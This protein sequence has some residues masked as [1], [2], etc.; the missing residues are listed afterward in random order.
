MDLPEVQQCRPLSQDPCEDL[1]PLAGPASPR[2]WDWAN[3]DEC[4]NLQVCAF[5]LVPEDSEPHE[6]LGVYRYR[7]SR[8][9][10]ELA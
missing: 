7:E 3:K 2:R 10:P 6:E 9:G 4:E 5:F 1:V 8:C